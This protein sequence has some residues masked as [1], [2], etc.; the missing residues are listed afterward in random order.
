MSEVPPNGE[1]EE[2]EEPPPE[3]PP[4][5]PAVGARRNGFVYVDDIWARAYVARWHPAD[6]GT[7]RWP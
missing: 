1:P 5:P 7:G 4:D 6:I 3:L 2:P